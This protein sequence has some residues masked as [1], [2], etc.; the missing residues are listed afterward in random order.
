MADR[1][2]PGSAAGE[3]GFDVL[4]ER[5]RGVV[6]KLETGSLGLE[7]SLAVYEEGV[8]LS[9]RGGEI[10]DQAERRIEL[11]TRGDG[12]ERAVPMPNTGEG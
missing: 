8:L 5:L 9:R 7:Q 4:L 12:G 6:E 2:K 3:E 10:L 1:G 11:L